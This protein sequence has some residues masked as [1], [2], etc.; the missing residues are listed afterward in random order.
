MRNN[1]SISDQG[2]A[3]LYNKSR[4][5][6]YKLYWSQWTPTDISDKNL[7]DIYNNNLEYFTIPSIIL[8][9]ILFG[10]CSCT[11]SY[12]YSY[13]KAFLSGT[14]CHSHL[15]LSSLKPCLFSLSLSVVSLFQHLE[16]YVYLFIIIIYQPT[17][18]TNTIIQWKGDDHILK[19]F[20][21]FLVVFLAG[22]K[23]TMHWRRTG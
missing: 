2:Y 1:I 4:K 18:C 20:I 10:H 6:A 9:H 7:V 12:T 17:T 23:C 14:S 5:A 15:I 21:W 19:W 13:T 3:I 22:E 8:Y 16:L 11:C